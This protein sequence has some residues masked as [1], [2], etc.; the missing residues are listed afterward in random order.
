[1]KRVAIYTRVSTGDQTTDSQTHALK[2]VA[3][4]SGWEVIH[5]FE[6]RAVSGSV[7]R[8]SRPA[9]KALLE[10]CTRREIDIIACWSIDR[11][12]RS[13]QDL[14]GFLQDIDSL[15]VDLYMHRQAIDTSTPSGKLLFHVCGVF[16]EFERSIISERVR[17]GLDKARAKGK[18]LGRPKVSR[19][20][21]AEIRT[22]LE[23]GVGILKTAKTLGVGSGTVQRIKKEMADR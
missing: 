5:I 10:A 13:L 22:M 19:D 12:G 6:D 11:L 20:K 4:K 16:A 7:S 9:F 8:T 1:M 17:A 14:V 18:R 21:E 2:E 3:E 15:G 23:D